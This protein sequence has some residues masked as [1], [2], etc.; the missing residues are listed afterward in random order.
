M[1]SIIFFLGFFIYSILSIFLRIYKFDFENNE[2]IYLYNL[3]LKIDIL[4]L[5]FHIITG[6]LLLIPIIFFPQII[7]INIHKDTSIWN[8]NYF[9][10]TG[11]FLILI[12]HNSGN[13]LGANYLGPLKYSKFGVRPFAKIAEKLFE[14]GDD[15]G[16]WYL[17]KSL[18]NLQKWLRKMKNEVDVLNDVIN[19][20]KTLEKYKSSINFEKLLSFSKNMISFP[21]LNLVLNE[22]INFEKDEELNWTKHFK[23]KK[24]ISISRTEVISIFFGILTIIISVIRLIPENTRPQILNKILDPFLESNQGLPLI[25]LYIFFVISLYLYNWI[26]ENKIDKDKISLM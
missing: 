2:W 14:M 23:E 12:N 20:L 25:I 22:L 13:V 26:T 24:F 19:R 17:I 18:V 15:E 3:N 21:K 10:G 4:I 7:V 8:L 11:L 9:I 6:I 16:V 1:I 5:I